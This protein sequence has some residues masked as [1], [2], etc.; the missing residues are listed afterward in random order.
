MSTLERHLFVNERL[1]KEEMSAVSGER[2]C[3]AI[4]KPSRG[5]LF[6]MSRIEI[7]DYINPGPFRRRAS[8]FLCF[9]RDSFSLRLRRSDGFS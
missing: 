8:S 2:W 1:D 5:G 7:Q 3:A 4:K 9:L 6:L